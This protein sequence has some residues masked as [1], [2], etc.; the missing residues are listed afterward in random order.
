[1]D[2][3]K[4]KSHYK[5]IS[6]LRYFSGYSVYLTIF[7]RTK[8]FFNL[9][10]NYPVQGMATKQNCCSRSSKRYICMKDTKSMTVTCVS[11][12]H[13]HLLLTLERHGDPPPAISVYSTLSSPFE[14]LHLSILDNLWSM[15]TTSGRFGL[16]R[17]VSARFSRINVFQPTPEKSVR[18]FQLR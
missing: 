12:W 8:T 13:L 17:L 10:I 3:G 4:N 6:S 9:I 5:L 1:M 16:L 15:F 11:L 14:C 18:C 2:C 7:S